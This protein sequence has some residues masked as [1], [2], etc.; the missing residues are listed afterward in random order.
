MSIYTVL[1]ATIVMIPDIQLVYFHTYNRLNPK[2]NIA[3]SLSVVCRAHTNALLENLQIFVMLDHIWAA[4]IFVANNILWIFSVHSIYRWL[5]RDTCDFAYNTTKD[6]AGNTG[7][8]S[9]Y[10]YNGLFCVSRPWVR[11]FTVIVH[12]F[13][14]FSG[15]N[16]PRNSKRYGNCI[17]AQST[18]RE[19]TKYC[20]SAL[21]RSLGKS[22]AACCAY[23]LIKEMDCVRGPR[24][25]LGK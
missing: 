20:T 22:S 2:R 7:V 18:V 16:A 14:H 3:I 1:M 4:S 24:K 5:Q 15:L 12:F 13:A 8:S 21:C 6:R 11:I 23:K 10:C 19:C 17:T 25:E 9:H